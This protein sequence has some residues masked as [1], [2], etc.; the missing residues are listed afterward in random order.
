MMDY[1]DVYERYPMGAETLLQLEKLAKQHAGEVL[2]DVI[3]DSEQQKAVNK[4]MGEDL[5]KANA[6]I[7]QLENELKS[8]D[9][10]ISKRRGFEFLMEYFKVP[11]DE[12]PDPDVTYY[13]YKSENSEQR[14]CPSC[15]GKYKTTVETVFGPKEV[16]CNDCY[17]G[18]QYWST[19]K[20][21][22][23][24]VNYISMQNISEKWD[25]PRVQI[26]LK[27]EDSEY[28]LKGNVSCRSLFL[29]PEA[30]AD[31]IR[32]KEKNI[33]GIKLPEAK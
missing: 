24:K 32:E 28:K 11:K 8:A 13:I 29:T 23:A 16:T 10:R 21:K 2:Q 19:Y 17:S 20:I 5:S 33:I 18:K 27:G 15:D 14:P 12:M 26:Y 30:A 6:K 7:R 3:N 31:A 9:E 22:P 4:R 1:E 25:S